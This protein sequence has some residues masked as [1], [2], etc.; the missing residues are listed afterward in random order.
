MLYIF[1]NGSNA[2]YF[3]E[4]FIWCHILWKLVFATLSAI[5]E[6]KKCSLDLNHAN[7]PILWDFYV[8]CLFTQFGAENLVWRALR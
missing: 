8:F 4:H 1:G 3:S 2:G 6:R 5:D 7:F